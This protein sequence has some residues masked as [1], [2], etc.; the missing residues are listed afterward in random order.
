M[1]KK[2]V[3]IFWGPP[4]SGKGTQADRLGKKMK[5]PVISTGE[6]LRHEKNKQTALGKQISACLT[7]GRLVSNEIVEKILDARLRKT[8]THAGFILDGYPRRLSQLRLFKKRLARLD[9]KVNLVFA[10]YIKVSNREVKSRLG[11]RL[12]C[13]CGAE[14][15]I[16]YNPP[17]QEG[18]C[19]LC[20]GKLYRREDDAPEIVQTRLNRFHKRIKPLLRDWQKHYPL[21]MINGEQSIK[22]VRREIEEKVKEMIKEN[23]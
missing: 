21:I 3:I 22:E 20:G 19:D 16:I 17:K 12:V 8:D 7:R 15:H 1:N 13:D 11:G 23:K 18:I 4:G 9:E 2:M 14:Y 5:L 6:L 10:F